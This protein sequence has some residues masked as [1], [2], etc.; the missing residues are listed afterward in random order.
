M[1]IYVV[2][3]TDYEWTELRKAFRDRAVAEQYVAGLPS[4][5]KKHYHYPIK[6]LELVE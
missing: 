3:E 5:W 6:E 4:G 1:K 2:L